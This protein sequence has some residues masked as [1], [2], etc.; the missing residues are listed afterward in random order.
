MTLMTRLSRL[1][2]ADLN[3]VLDRLEEPDILL[4]HALRDMQEALAADERALAV[5]RLDRQRV[6]RR[7]ETLSQRRMNIAAELDICLDAGKDDLARDLL[8]RR[9]EHDRLESLLGQ[10]ERDLDARIERLAETIDEHRSRL[11]AMRAEAALV[12][13]TNA[14][15]EPPVI[16]MHG[17]PAPPVRDTDVEVALL[18]EKRRRLS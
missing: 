10:S 2:R 14:D 6:Q 15:T 13:A 3:A 18:A 1:V 4:A 8:R 12:T 5:L 9:L 7:R 17:E 11:T 16:D